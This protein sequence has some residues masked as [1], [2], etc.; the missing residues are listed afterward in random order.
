MDFNVTRK[1]YHQLLGT[2]K[3]LV[4]QR[5]TQIDFKK[6]R[7]QETNERQTEKRLMGSKNKVEQSGE[8]DMD[9]AEKIDG[10]TDGQR[11]TVKGGQG[12]RKKTQKDSDRESRQRNR[13]E[14]AAGS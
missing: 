2:Q 11:Q 3:K 14:G 8:G 10:D 12:V 5:E 7:E 9:M 13:E 1:G 6:M 4:L